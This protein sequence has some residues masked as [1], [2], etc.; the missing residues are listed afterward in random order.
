MAKRIGQA[1]WA[2]CVL[3]ALTFVVALIV[4]FFA[5]WLGFWLVIALAAVLCIS[6][7]ILGTR[8]ARGS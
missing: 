4:K 8:A 7:A 2:L 6:D 1:I 3:A 5:G